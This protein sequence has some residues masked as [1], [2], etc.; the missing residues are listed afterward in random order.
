[1]KSAKE[2]RHLSAIMLTDMVGYTSLSQSDERPALEL[3][4]EHK[5]TPLFSKLRKDPRFQ[6]SCEMVGLPPSLG[7]PRG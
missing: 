6:E 1:M 2:E 5:Y 4:E 7:E 3:L